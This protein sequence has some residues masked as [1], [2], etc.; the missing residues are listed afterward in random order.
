M[1]FSSQEILEWVAIS[2][3]GG[4]CLL[5]MDLCLLCL[6]QWQVDSLLQVPHGKPRG[7]EANPIKYKGLNRKEQKM[8]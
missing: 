4:S 8:D 7:A 6:L 1:D 3:C 5:R 2:Y